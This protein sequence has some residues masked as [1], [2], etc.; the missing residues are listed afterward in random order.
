MLAASAQVI[1]HRTHRMAQAGANPTTSDLLE[2]NRMIQEKIEAAA[3]SAQAVG[4]EMLRLQAQFIQQS[5][6]LMTGGFMGGRAR[7]TSGLGNVP[8]A[9]AGSTR[10]ATSLACSASKGLQPFHG[11]AVANSKRLGKGKRR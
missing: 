11:R 9:V 10:I 7:K 6:Q 3:E 4:T 2:F 5:L 1:G 8:N